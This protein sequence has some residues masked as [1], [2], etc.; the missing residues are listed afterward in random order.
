MPSKNGSCAPPSPPPP[1]DGE[2]AYIR[3]NFNFSGGYEPCA[4]FP[5]AAFLKELSFRSADVRHAAKVVQEIKA[6]RSSVQQREKER[7]ERATLV[8]QEKL[9]RGKVCNRVQS[10]AGHL[11]AFPF[12]PCHFLGS[13]FWKLVN[14]TANPLQGRVYALPDV[15]IRPAFGGKGRKVTGTLEAHSNGF[16]YTSPKGEELDI[17][18]RCVCSLGVGVRLDLTVALLKLALAAVMLLPSLCLPSL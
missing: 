5:R 10:V 6:L 11:L 14:G 18:Y 3:L 9:V 8:Q 1:Q 15:W 13:A 4:R 2:H 16:R 7:A 17:M 12:I